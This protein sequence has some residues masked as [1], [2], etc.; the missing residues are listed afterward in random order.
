MSIVKLLL[1]WGGLAAVVSAA[2]GLTYFIVLPVL[3]PRLWP[4]TRLPLALLPGIVLLSIALTRHPGA[5]LPTEASSVGRAAS[6][7]ALAGDRRLRTPDREPTLVPKRFWQA[8]Q[9]PHTAQRST[10]VNRQPTIAT[11]VEPAALIT[12][13][14]AVEAEKRYEELLLLKAH[15]DRAVMERLVEYERTHNPG[16]MRAE[17]VQ[18]AVERWE[19]DIR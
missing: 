9:A 11:P 10:R 15:G 12:S 1:R 16:A 5:Y 6:R 7:A 18:A 13:T 3:L 19:R 4:E 8:E 17:L 2:A 14:S